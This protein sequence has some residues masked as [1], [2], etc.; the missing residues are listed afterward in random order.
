M[1][2]RA[3]VLG[4][5]AGVAATAAF[6]IRLGAS[7]GGQTLIAEPLVV[8]FAYR[9][10]N[11]HVR[12]NETLSHMLGRHGMNAMEIHGFVT[13][14]RSEGLDPR[15]ILPDMRFDVRIPGGHSSPDLIEVRLDDETRLRVARDSSSGWKAERIPI[16]WS[17]SIHIVLGSFSSATSSLDAAIRKEVGGDDLPADE[18]NR[19]VWATA[20][21]VYGWIIDFTRDPRPGDRFRIV[22]ERLES[23]AGDMQFGRIMAADFEVGGDPVKAYLMSDDQGNN[24]YYD[25]EGLSL[26]RAFLKYPVSFRRISSGFSRRRY[27]PVLQ[28]Y[29]A[30]LGTDYSANIGTPIRATGEG[31]VEFAGRNGSYGLVV[32]VRHPTDIQTRYA[33]MS[34]IENGIRPGVRVRQGQT[35]GRVGMTGLANG[36]HVHYEFLK[37]GRQVDHRAIDLGDGEPLPEARRG[38]FAAARAEFDRLLQS[39]S[40]HP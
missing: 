28:R 15:R 35:I 25:G 33:H 31:V 27:H 36:P 26:H 10:E 20:E 9:L 32:Y 21:S 13:T 22:Y 16:A 5:L 7:L 12:R 23:E 1:R 4:G 3:L 11:D 38:E 19:L 37:N 34:R 29:R 2:R 24:A 30:H 40:Q 17:T 14:A 6:V 8:S 18:R 39:A